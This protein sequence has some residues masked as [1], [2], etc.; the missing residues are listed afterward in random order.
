MRKILIVDDDPNVLVE[1]SEYFVDDYE[2][3]TASSAKEAIERLEGVHLALVDMYMETEESGI[4]VLK[5]AKQMDPLLQCIVL[6]AYGG[7]SN[8]VEAMKVGAYDYV[9]KQTEN[10]YEVLAHRV[11]RAL[12]YRESISRRLEAT[13]VVDIC[14]HTSTMVK[15]GESVL[16]AM[17]R[18]FS[19]IV[20]EE[21]KKCKFLKNTGD[22]YLITFPTAS[23]AVSSAF[24]I[25]AEMKKYN[26]AAEENRKMSLRFAVNYGEVVTEPSGERIGERVIETFRMADLR[27]EDSLDYGKD[28]QEF[29]EKDYI[30]A[31]ERVYNILSDSKDMSFSPLG[32]FNLRGLPGLHKIYEVTFSKHENNSH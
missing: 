19:S 22:G 29:P 23:D 1:L 7:V 26:E 9:E 27:Q 8:V 28:N 14:E 25:L 6:T 16:G 10:V 24:S 15:V 21:S 31:S 2:I 32:F 18:T 12:E 5:A 30:L 3:T 17:L 4:E 11:K 13:M 20:Q